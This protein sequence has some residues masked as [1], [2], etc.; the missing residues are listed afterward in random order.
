MLAVKLR[1]VRLIFLEHVVNGG[2]QHSGNSDNGL[3]MSPAFL[4]CKIT[5]ADFREPFGTN[6]TESALNE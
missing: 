2:E 6:R 3:F 1:I 4:E 5:I